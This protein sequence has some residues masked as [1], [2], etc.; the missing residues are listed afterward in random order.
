MCF[1]DSGKDLLHESLIGFCHFSKQT[2]LLGVHDS[3][4]RSRAGGCVV[5]DDEETWV[6]R[7]EKGSG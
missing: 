7:V 3:H 1:L 6:R 4:T 5:H 2:H